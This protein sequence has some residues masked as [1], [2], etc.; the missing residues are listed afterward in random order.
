[1]SPGSAEA[2]SRAEDREFTLA[3]SA[4]AARIGVA[5]ATLRT[6]D[7]R[8]GLGPAAHAM[9][10][11]RRYDPHDVARLTLM[12]RA[13]LR[14]A[15]PAEAA[16]YAMG[17]DA[18]ALS[19]LAAEQDPEPVSARPRGSSP[20][21]FGAAMPLP[22]DAGAPADQLAAAALAL[23]VAAVQGQLRGSIAD[24]GV[25]RTWDA[26]IRPVL[27]ALGEGWAGT[28]AGIEVEHVLTECITAVMAHAMVETP[29]DAS[30]APVLLAC[31]PGE[32]HS[33]PLRA[34]GAALAEQAV[35]VIMLGGDTPVPALVAAVQAREPAAVFLW[36]HMD[37]SANPHLIDRLPASRYLLGGPAWDPTAMVADIRLAHDLAAARDALLP[38]RM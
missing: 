2:S 5:P 15:S 13:L 3:V 18:G 33:L 38:S 28:G 24:C 9:G 20:L 14:G 7:R 8:Y 16:E 23:D 6:W 37:R 35:S 36:A 1:M 31:M 19:E 10:R 4:V 11:H 34:L 27:G 29:T 12:K 17:A 21:E 26:V 30:G 22:P 25:I 32:H